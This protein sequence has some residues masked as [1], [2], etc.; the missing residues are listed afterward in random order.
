ME[1]IN[2]VSC[3]CTTCK[4]YK[5]TPLRPMV[6]LPMATEFQETVAMDLKFYNGK[7]VHLADHSTRL[8]A[9]SFIPNKNPDTIL[10]DMFK[11]LI[12]V[13]G[14]PEKFSADNGGEFANSKFIEMAESLGI[15]V[16]TVAGESPLSKGLIERHNLVVAEMLDQVLEDTQCHSDLAVS[17]CINAKIPL[18]SIHGF[19]FYQLAIGK[20]PKL[21]STLNKK[22]PA[23]ARQPASKI[24]SNNLDVIHRARETFIASESSEKIRRALS[25]NVRTSGDVKY[26]TGD[27]VYYRQ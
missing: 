26:I 10:T 20:N 21:P 5:K 8:S 27:C 22:V 2:N 4:L 19:S 13:Y 23:L 15:T 3:N 16:K 24:V 9:S 17:W 14:T 12:S 11:I 25:H 1:E 7:I 18:H 6:G